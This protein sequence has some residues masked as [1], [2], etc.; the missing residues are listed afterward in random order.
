MNDQHTTV[1]DE[2]DRVDATVLLL[3]LDETHPVWHVDEIAAEI[4]DAVA[5]SD[6][7]ARLHASRLVHRLEDFVLVTRA[8]STPA[9]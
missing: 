6:A 4:D 2:E 1:A 7:L 5:A 3:L 9:A 8:G